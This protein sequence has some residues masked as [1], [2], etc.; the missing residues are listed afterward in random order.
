MSTVKRPYCS[1]DCAYAS[2]RFYEYANTSPGS[3][4]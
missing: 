1:A 3:A 4:D 2:N